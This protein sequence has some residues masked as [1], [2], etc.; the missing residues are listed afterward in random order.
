MEEGDQH[1]QI[2]RRC[3]VLGGVIGLVGLTPAGAW[4]ARSSAYER[5]VSFRHLHT[6][7]SLSTVYWERGRYVPDALA[8]INHVMRDFRTDEVASINVRLVDLLYAMRRR[9]ETNRPIELV[10]AYRSPAT[11]AMLRSQ[12]GRVAKNS[13]H[14]QGM[15]VDFKVQGYNTRTLVG[16]ARRLQAGGVGYYPR[17]SFVHV[18]VGKVRFWRG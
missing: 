4:A 3:F 2:T 10:S 5:S 13:L 12:G 17:A 16:L 15:A 11:N 9:L 8:K 18:D 14:M 7:E 6:G 1:C